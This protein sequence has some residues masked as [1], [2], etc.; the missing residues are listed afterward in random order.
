MSFILD[1][2]KKSEKERLHGSVPDI[3][4]VQDTVLYEPGN[5]SFWKYILL[6]ALLLNGGILTAWLV[7]QGA[8]KPVAVDSTDSQ[9]IESAALADLDTVSSA[10]IPAEINNN[11]QI[12]DPV[13]P[14]ET[15]RVSRQNK[16]GIAGT[17]AEGDLDSNTTRNRVAEETPESR[18]T[19]SVL[20]SAPAEKKDRIEPM[21]SR[22]ERIL[23]LPVPAEQSLPVGQYVSIDKE[24]VFTLKELPDS[25]RKDLPEIN[26]SAYM[27]SSNPMSRLVTINDQIWHEGETLMPGMKLE[28]ITE[29]K[30]AVCAVHS[31]SVQSFKMMFLVNCKGETYRYLYLPAFF[32]PVVNIQL[33][34]RTKDERFIIRHQFIPYGIV[35]FIQYSFYFCVMKCVVEA[36]MF[37]CFT[38]S[39]IGGHA[40]QYCVIMFRF[41]RYQFKAVPCN[42]E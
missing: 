17:R 42:I 22:E 32:E 27:Y 18:D 16:A 28:E 31:G 29:I 34:S 6:V 5:R 12:P 25:I 7:F 19:K 41:E 10:V 40:L 15:D 33:R 23:S 24:K 30:N 37:N 21:L 8:A 3:M 4:T 38:D 36:N 11:D 39:R 20:Y 2:L 9:K 26:I 14:V 35:F 13:L 1:A